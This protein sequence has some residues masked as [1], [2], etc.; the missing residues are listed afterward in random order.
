MADDL[1]DLGAPATRA[2]AA[3]AVTELDQLVDYRERD[4]LVHPDR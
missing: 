4:L 3:I 1:Q 2:L